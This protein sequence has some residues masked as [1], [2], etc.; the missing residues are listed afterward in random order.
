M[1][2][3]HSLHNK[4]ENCIFNDIGRDLNVVNVTTIQ[5]LPEQFAALRIGSP[6]ASTLPAPIPQR[7]ST[8]STRLSPAQVHASIN[9]ITDLIVKIVTALHPIRS[10]QSRHLERQLNSLSQSVTLVGLAADAYGL[11]PLG[12]SLTAVIGIK[13]EG[14]REGLRVVLQKCEG[15]YKA[16]W[17]KVLWGATDDGELALHSSSV[18]AYREQ[19]DSSLQEAASYVEFFQ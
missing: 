5:I 10:K 1:A 13:L 6:L 11:T 12:G 8:P 7:L 19:L 15:R 16:S 17:P 14:C 9:I 3:S 2:F 4:L 18:L